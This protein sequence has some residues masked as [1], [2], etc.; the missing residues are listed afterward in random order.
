MK[1]LSIAE[2]NLRKREGRERICEKI[3]KIKEEWKRKEE[4]KGKSEKENEEEKEK[5]LEKPDR[6][7]DNLME[8]SLERQ[9]KEMKDGCPIMQNL[10]RPIRIGGGGM[11]REGGKIQ[12][13]ITSRAMSERKFD[14]FRMEARVGEI[15]MITTIFEMFL[16]VKSLAGEGETK[17]M[18]ETGRKIN[19]MILKREGEWKTNIGEGLIA[20]LNLERGNFKRIREE[21]GRIRRDEE[22]F[23]KDVMGSLEIM[24]DMIRREE[25]LI[26]K[27]AEEIERSVDEIK[28]EEGLSKERKEE[29]IKSA[30]RAGKD[31]RRRSTASGCAIIERLMRVVKRIKEEDEKRRGK[32]LGRVDSDE[33]EESEEEGEERPERKDGLERK[34]FGGPRSQEEGEDGLFGRTISAELGGRIKDIM[35]V[36]GMDTAGGERGKEKGRGAEIHKG[37][38]L[39]LQYGPKLRDFDQSELQLE[40]GEGGPGKEMS[41]RCSTAEEGVRAVLG[42]VTLGA[43]KQVA[44]VAESGRGF[45]ATTR[46]EWKNITSPILTEAAR[47]GAREFLERELERSRDLLDE[48]DPIS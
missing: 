18:E 31:M 39:T 15:A 25:D 20:L 4:R 14:F 47:R 7:S 30:K 22:E 43:G 44:I 10:T 17:E 19:E 24:K 13:I 48:V 45:F 35:R 36:I 5:E 38:F 2:A 6:N 34:I 29:L 23:F 33:E 9:R 8:K 42:A 16:G 27:K 40:E 28:R 12:G 41:I 21:G 46:R 1:V 3:K 32:H 37:I 11:G 26:S